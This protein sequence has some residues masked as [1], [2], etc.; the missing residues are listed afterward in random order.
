MI[1]YIYKL[2]CD[3]IDEFYIGSSFDIEARKKQHKKIVII[4]IQKN[5]I[6]KFINT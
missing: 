3:G 2:C 4:L 5:I 6:L 1:G